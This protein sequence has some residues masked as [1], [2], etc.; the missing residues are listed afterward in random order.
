MSRFEGL[1]NSGHPLETFQNSRRGKAGFTLVELLVVVGI[2]AALLALLLPALGRARE[3]ARAVAC[4]GNI[5]Q[6]GIATLAY[7]GRNQGYLPVPVLGTNLMGGLPE[8]AIW[9]TSQPGI[10]DFSQGTLIPD[11]GGPR[12]AE[13]LFKCPT[14]EEP[15]QLSA[16][17]IVPFMPHNISYIFNAHVVDSYNVRLGW[18]SKRITKIRCP[19][20]KVLLYENGD[21]PGLNAVPVAYDPSVYKESVH[22]IIALRHHNRSNVFYADGHVELFDSLLFKDDGGT[23]ILDNPAYVRHFRLDSE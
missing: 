7:A 22:L 18:K 21:C 15:R 16:F 3:A 9:G 23:R 11:L 14:D 5:R 13:E 6:I 1:R 20:R 10:L 17:H 19:A 12:L 8:S 2:I 4:A